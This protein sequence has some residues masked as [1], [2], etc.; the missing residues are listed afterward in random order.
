MVGR[1][2]GYGEWRHREV[3]ERRR[4]WR[5]ARRLGR[6]YIGLEVGGV[7]VG[8]VERFE[9]RERGKALP[10]P[11]GRRGAYLEAEG[12]QAREAAERMQPLIGRRCG[13]EVQVGELTQV[14]ANAIEGALVECDL[15]REGGGSR[16]W[17]LTI[18]VPGERGSERA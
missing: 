7:C 10:D 3:Q 4:G 18:G 6:P 5:R 17:D 9:L 14:P 13:A 1:R 2:R 16:G 11:F 8:E 12:S 15:S